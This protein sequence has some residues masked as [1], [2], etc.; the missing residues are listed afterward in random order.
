MYRVNYA[1]YKSKVK[2]ET[3]LGFVAEN[4]FFIAFAIEGSAF[5]EQEN[6][7]QEKIKEDLS[8][9]QLINLSSLD[10]FVTN[11]ITK[12]NLP[13]AISMAIGY[14]SQ[15][16]MYL[17]TVGKGAIYLK[18]E[19]NFSRII[20]GDKSASG[21]VNKLDFYIF[22]SDKFTEILQNDEIKTA[23]GDRD[24]DEVVDYFQSTPPTEK[25]F[26]VVAVFVKFEDNL[27]QPEEATIE[28]KTE[29]IIS[30]TNDSQKNVLITKFQEIFRRFGKRRIFTLIAVVCILFILIWSVVL[31]YSRRKTSETNKKIDLAK[32][33][34]DRKLRQAEDVAFLNLTKSMGLIAESKKISENLKKDLGEERKEIIAID[35]S[36]KNAESRI[37]KKEDKNFE[38]FFD[39]TIE[40]KGAKG[41]KFYLEGEN[42]SI[43]NNDKSTLYSLSLTKKS[44]DKKSANQIKKASLVA[45]YKDYNLIYVSGEGVYM[46][47][48]NDKTKKV[49][50]NDS[51]WGVIVAMWIYNGNLYLLDSVKGD[52]YKYL[53]T[54]NGYSK[55][56]SYLGVGI[57]KNSNSIAIDSSVY[58]GFAD[59]IFKYNAGV[60]DDFKT[61]WPEK[62]V[63]LNKIFTSA[64][65]EKVYAW[66]KKKGTIYIL[67][68]NGGYDRQINSSILSKGSDFVVYNDAT[69]VLVSEKIYKIDLK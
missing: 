28:D 29:E 23:I 59:Q 42:L 27:P 34:I 58:V 2:E 62:N 18:R 46:I 7:F 26:G 13:P 5:S 32:E 38:E 51:D 30:E 4:N 19:S 49:I 43:I 45:S 41:N 12:Y 37:V 60:K 9:F 52:I 17:K 33:Q 14:K 20:E 54:D 65:V 61:S 15:N 16:I 50:D 8:S 44:L 47:D 57:L 6:N 56:S 36:I 24:P 67:G 21:F 3:R 64:D 63:N 11:T 66:D 48:T 39:L 68:K 10:Q 35:K 1:V 25:D 55:K 40:S 69:F 31:G 53:V 22:A